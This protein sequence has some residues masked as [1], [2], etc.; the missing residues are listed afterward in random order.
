MAP[1]EYVVE[2]Y[3]GDIN[4][5]RFIINEYG[6]LGHTYDD[7]QKRNIE[8]KMNFV[9]VGRVCLE[10]GIMRLIDLAERIK[11]NKLIEIN[12]VGPIDQNVMTIIKSLKLKNIHFHGAKP[13]K[14][15]KTYLKAADCMIMPSLSDAYCIAVIEALSV[16][17]PVIVSSRTGCKDIVVKNDLG[18]VFDVDDVEQLESTVLAY[19]E[20]P[21]VEINHY[22]ERIRS[23]FKSESDN[24]YLDRLISI[25]NKL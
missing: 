17:V 23:Y 14:D 18:F 20:L 8:R 25:Y 13:K 11:N 10:K 2:S 5:D 12:I 1:S 16:G 15:I 21:L 22:K 19:Q 24:S 7:D 6:V 4:K 9:Y 3:S